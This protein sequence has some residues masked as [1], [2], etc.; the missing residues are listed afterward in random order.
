MT[1]TLTRQVDFRTLTSRGPSASTIIRL[2]MACNDLS[3]ANQALTEWKQEQ[4]GERKSRQQGAGL[5]FVRMQMAHLH[6]G[7]K[8]IQDIKKDPI[9]M[10]LVQRCDSRTR[11]SF[12]ELEKYLRGGIHR[13]EFESLIGNIRNNLTFHYDEQGKRIPKSLSSLASK[14]D[15]FGSVT[16]GN[17][18]HVWYFQAADRVVNNAICFQIWEIPEGSDVTAEADK[19]AMR[20][21]EIFL[22][23][24]D[25]AGEFVWQYTGSG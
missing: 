23:F 5:Y 20:C 18:A 16:R 10:A 21:H 17:T 7:M 6:E 19:K 11:E 25:F 8:V 22:T 14:A 13:K 1:R 9:L 15:H 3:L 4:R 2:M 24:V 12:G